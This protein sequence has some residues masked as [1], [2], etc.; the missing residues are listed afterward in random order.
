MNLWNT[1]LDI[2]KTPVKENSL[3]SSNKSIPKASMQSEIKT[4]AAIKGEITD[5]RNN[6]ITLRFDNGETVTA[7]MEGSIEFSIGDTASFEVISNSAGEIVLRTIK[8]GTADSSDLT[9]QKALDAAGLSKNDKN[10]TIISELLKNHLSIDKQS[11]LN[12]LKYSHQFKNAEISSLV[13]MVKNNI[14]IS[15]ETISQYESYKNYEHRILQQTSEIAD[16]ISSLLD[17]NADSTPAEQLININNSLIKILSDNQKAAYNLSENIN[18]LFKADSNSLKEFI[19]L[20]KQIS[21]DSNIITELENN[22]LPVKHAEELLYDILSLKELHDNKALQNLSTQL[23]TFIETSN[24]YNFDSAFINTISNVLPE[25]ELSSILEHMNEI[26]SL[27]P[28]LHQIKTSNMPVIDVLQN[29]NKLLPNE[30]NISIIKLI[31]SKPYKDMVKHEF[32]KN[33][34]LTPEELKEPNSVKELYSRIYSQTEN[35]EHMLNKISSSSAEN[36]LTQTTAVKDNLNFMNLINQMFNYVQ[37]PIH[38]KNSDIHSEL[39]VY[40]SKKNLKDKKGSISV[41]LHLDLEHLGPLDIHIELEGEKI[42]SKFYISDDNTY[43]ILS[44]NIELLEERL[45]EKGYFLNHELLHNQKT[46]NLIDDFLAQSDDSIL[47]KR[48]SFDIRA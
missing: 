38:M 11:I 36:L 16:G 48:Y 7:R 40:T 14:P 28:L 20:L 35:L 1:N 27:K 46:V 19:P 33:M 37:L 30:E 34:T 23:K 15:K 29:I 31:S 18:P 42:N 32:I 45:V 43:S 3:P 39:Y 2:K 12:I 22:S 13:S 44:K 26:P 21:A 25:Q 41:L 8:N 47:M 6:T 5:I 24:N 10:M 9:V 17:I 4:D